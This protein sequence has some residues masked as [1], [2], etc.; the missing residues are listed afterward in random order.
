MPGVII[1]TKD[2]RVENTGASAGV[3]NKSHHPGQDLFW[4]HIILLVSCKLSLNP[5]CHYDY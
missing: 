2:G 5:S 4:A 1:G 3:G